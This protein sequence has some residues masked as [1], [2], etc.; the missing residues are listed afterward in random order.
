M[1]NSNTGTSPALGGTSTSVPTGSSHTAS[2][3]TSS[4]GGAIGGASHLGSDAERAMREA[5]AQSDQVL[6][7]AN[8]ETQETATDLK[9]QVRSAA[10]SAKRQARE[11]TGRVA[12]FIQEQGSKLVQSR[13]D[14]AA[15]EVATIK[16]A[17]R[18][19][20]EQLDKE[21]DTTLAGYVNS[22][23]DTV[24]NV[25]SYL[26]DTDL[27]DVYH[28]VSDTIRRHPAWTLGGLF[29]VGLV[30]SRF[31]KASDEKRYDERGRYSGAHSGG[32]GSP[33]YTAGHDPYN[34]ATSIGGGDSAPYGE[35][36]VTN[37]SGPYATSTGALPPQTL[38]MTDPVPP[39]RAGQANEKPDLTTGSTAANRTTPGGSSSV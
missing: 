13:K 35:R 37:P 29:V 3:S 12:N 1:E 8:R 28:D 5:K 39:H 24:G 27:S 15:A 21:D 10:D 17:I 22:A 32:V 4:G 30:A 23:A 25:E 34:R 20:G 14:R 18:K 7:D 19:A 2:G 38:P 36:P 31:L 26:R 11:S 9:H 33:Y 16:H 6:N